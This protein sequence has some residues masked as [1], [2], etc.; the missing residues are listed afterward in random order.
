VGEIEE[1][2]RLARRLWCLWYYRGPL[3]EGVGY[4]TDALTRAERVDLELL[5]NARYINALLLWTMGES[6]LALASVRAAVAVARTFGESP[7][8]AWSLYQMA[9][10]LGW[11]HNAWDEAI[12]L[13]RESLAL[14]RELG[15]ERVSWLAQNALGDLGT[16]VALRGD[17]DEGVA[18]IEEAVAQHRALGHHYGCAIRLAELA[19][20]DQLDQR[21]ARAAQRYAESLQ[22]LQRIGDA[23]SVAQPMSGLAGLIASQGRYAETARVLGMLEAVRDRVGVASQTGPP[24]VWYPARAEGERAARAALG[25]AAFVAAFED[26]RL[27][28]L[29]NA[30]SEAI[31]LAESIAAGSSG[32]ELHPAPETGAG[33]YGLS[34]REQE[35][36]RL[37]A[38][39]WTDA[40]IA[41]ALFVSPRTVNAHVRGIF[42][43]LGVA[44]RREA[45]A[46]AMRD[47]LV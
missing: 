14:A 19:L 38:Q 15:T 28:S 47:G 20:I 13:A 17:R 1:E 43:K 40:E 25:D 22:L 36:L 45:A 37:L 21:P 34:A 46:V 29:G 5:A 3:H 23:M 44:N 31:S 12:P 24:A 2:L 41:E 6:D 9:L 30:V 35:V 4:L 39:R 16:M 10:V 8:L 32:P 7:T 33:A 26:G 27:L 42:A 11:D 18:L